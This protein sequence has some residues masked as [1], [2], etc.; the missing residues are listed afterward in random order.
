MT[1]FQLSAVRHNIIRH[2]IEFELPMDSD[3]PFWV[4]CLQRPH[5][6]LWRSLIGQEGQTGT[7]A[8]PEVRTSS[9]YSNFTAVASIMRVCSMFGDQG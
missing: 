4:V 6:G 2:S 3:V 8:E 9:I 1:R 5:L 7:I